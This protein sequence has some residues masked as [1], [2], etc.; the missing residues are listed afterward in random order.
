MYY[1]VVLC[2]KQIDHIVKT[3]AE[4]EAQVHLIMYN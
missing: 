1:L 4:F 2:A 3:E